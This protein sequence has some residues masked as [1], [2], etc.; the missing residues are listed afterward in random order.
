V[1]VTK[2]LSPCEQGLK[3]LWLVSKH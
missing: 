2:G 3:P 1:E